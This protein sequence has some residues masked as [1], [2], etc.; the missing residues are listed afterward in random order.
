MVTFVEL[1]LVTEQITS[2]VDDAAYGL[3]QKDLLQQADRGDVIPQ[4]GGF[5]KVRRRLPGSS[6]SSEAPIIHLHRPRHETKQ[7]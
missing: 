2:L 7:T 3:F 6:I 4:S 5:R 1:P